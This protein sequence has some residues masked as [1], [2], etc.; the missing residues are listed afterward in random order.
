MLATSSCEQS[1]YGCWLFTAGLGQYL[2]HG[3]I[4]TVGTIMPAEPVNRPR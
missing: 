1:L 2:Y 3:T 4:A